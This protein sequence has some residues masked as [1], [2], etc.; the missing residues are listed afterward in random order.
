MSDATTH[1][2]LDKVYSSRSAEELARDYDEW[3]QTYDDD[4]AEAG[5]RHPSICLALLARHVSPGK[6][7]VLDAGAGTGILGEWMRIVGYQPLVALDVSEGMLDVARRKDVY[8]ELTQGVMGSDPLPFETDRF[9]AAVS[10][11]V[12]TLGHA[13]PQAFDDLLRVV[14]PGGRIV[15]TVKDKLYYE[16]GFRDHLEDLIGQGRCSLIE[17]TDSYISMPRQHATSTSRALVIEVAASS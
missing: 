2:H 17:E 11:G 10:A 9:D 1:D 3:A 7:A 6:G 13:G 16:G 14:R 4:M 8:E 12:F 5:Y 15:V